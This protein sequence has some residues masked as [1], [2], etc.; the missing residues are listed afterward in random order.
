MN[1]NGGTFCSRESCIRT[2]CRAVYRI[3]PAIA[4]V[5][6]IWHATILQ[7]V[8]RMGDGC[9][10]GSSEYQINSEKRNLDVLITGSL[11]GKGASSPLLFSFFSRDFHPSPVISVRLAGES[12]FARIFL[13]GQSHLDRVNRVNNNVGNGAHSDLPPL[14][15]ADLPIW[16]TGIKMGKAWKEF[17]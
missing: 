1:V 4:I 10:L 13:N 3:W 14:F 5:I 12:Q 11:V 17:H 16:K 2:N 6:S 15:P 8:Q 7:W 9:R